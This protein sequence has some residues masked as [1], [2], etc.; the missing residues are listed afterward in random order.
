M[1]IDRSL[2]IKGS[3]AR[4]RNVLKREERIKVLLDQEKF[5]EENDTPFGLPKVSHRKPAVGGK[6]KKKKGPEEEEAK[7]A[8]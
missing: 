4:H 8:T 3:L 2:K 7:E 5:D 6:S 1:S